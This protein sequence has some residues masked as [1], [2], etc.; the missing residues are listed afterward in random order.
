MHG[1]R[2]ELLER[3]AAALGLPLEKVFISKTSSNEEYE[4]QMRNLLEKYS[5][6]GVNSVVFGDIF[7]EDLKKYREDNLA[8][9]QMKA[10]FP[11]WKR[12]TARL[13]REFIQNGFKAVITCVD[14]QVLDP[15]FA[16]REIDETLLADLPAGVDPCGENGEFHSF[17]YDG[18]IFSK[19]IPVRKGEVVCRENRFYFCDLVSA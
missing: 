12:D 18:P 1:V 5:Q 13:A 9:V 7:L 16:G 11:I 8:K 2:E 17:V 3:Q 15:N 4:N 19:P 6:T 10:I 14:S